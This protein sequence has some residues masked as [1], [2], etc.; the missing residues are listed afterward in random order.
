MYDAYALLD[1]YVNMWLPH[2]YM[3]YHGMNSTAVYLFELCWSTFILLGHWFKPPF[4][5]HTT[6]K[7]WCFSDASTDKRLG[8][9]LA[10]NIKPQYLCFP[11][12]SILKRW[13]RHPQVMQ[14]YTKL[15]LK[16]S[17]YDK[18]DRTVF[19]ANMTFQYNYVRPNKVPKQTVRREHHGFSGVC[20]MWTCKHN[21]YTHSNR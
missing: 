8:H 10:A 11:L 17:F 6:I 16:W 5:K 3:H 14:G 2:V 20:G 9:F 15:V 21:T 18:T 7:S 13:L 1:G 19:A 4:S 12:F